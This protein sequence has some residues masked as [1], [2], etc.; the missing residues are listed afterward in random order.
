MAFRFDAQVADTSTPNL[1]PL[2]DV[3]FLLLIFFM[4]SSTFLEESAVEVRLPEAT[5]KAPETLP[6]ALQIDVLASGDYR[7][8][9]VQ[10]DANDRNALAASLERNQVADQIL[11]VQADA[12]APHQ[13]VM[14]LLDLGAQLGVKS[15]QFQAK[16]LDKPS[17]GQ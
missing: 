11:V 10:V 14:T 7:I 17:E 9:G 16:D 5:G 4:V 13:S 6:D 3:V 8:S 12:R 1:T 2:I 15:V